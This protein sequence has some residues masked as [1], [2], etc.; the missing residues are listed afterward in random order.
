MFL[1]VFKAYFG[2]LKQFGSQKLLSKFTCQ[3]EYP[4]TTNEEGTLTILGTVG[5][6]PV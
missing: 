5:A 6:S 2:I 1:N 4:K 3:R